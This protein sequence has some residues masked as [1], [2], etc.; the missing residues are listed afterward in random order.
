[1]IA[2]SLTLQLIRMRPTPEDAPGIG[3]PACHHRLTLDQPNQQCPDLLIGTC[4]ECESWFLVH[5]DAGVMVRLPDER[6]LR[7]A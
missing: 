3:C 6:E 2:I 4:E 7:D 5:P 1:M